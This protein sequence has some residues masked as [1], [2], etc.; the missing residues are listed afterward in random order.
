MGRHLRQPGPGHVRAARTRLQ[1]PTELDQP[2]HRP[3]RIVQTPESEVQLGAV[4]AGD[5]QA[6][7]RRRPV[8]PVGQVGEGVVVALG[9]G[10]LGSVHQHVPGVK[11]EAGEGLPRGALG[12]G[13]LVGVVGEDQVDAAGVDVDRL[14][15]MAHGQNAAL[16]MP[17]RTAR[18]PGGV[19]HRHVALLGSLAAFPEHEVTGVFLVVRLISRGSA[20]L[21]QRGHVQL[22]QPSVGREPRDVEV[23]RSV[24]LVG[25]IAFHQRFHQSDHLRHVLGGPGI[26]LGALDPQAVAVLEEAVDEGLGQLSQAEASLNR[27]VDGPVVHVGEVLDLKHFKPLPLQVAPQHVLEEKG[28]EVSDVSRVVDRGAAGV[29]R[30]APRRHGVEL[31]EAAREGVVETERHQETG[32]DRGVSPNVTTLSGARQRV[33]RPT[34]RPGRKRP[35]R[36]RRPPPDPR[37]R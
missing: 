10:H 35:R 23:D 9:L 6:T 8:T 4:M 27:G 26:V 22:S 37:H 25:Q 11:P 16:Q 24:R 3:G 31:L 18:T 7:D 36:L 29:K 21:L 19:P 17:A 15:E 33:K 32:S 13:D 30:H 14:P 34:R 28:P 5:Q 20:A 12:L 2:L 1:T